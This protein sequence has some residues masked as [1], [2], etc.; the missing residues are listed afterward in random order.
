MHDFWNT[1]TPNY[2]WTW[3]TTRIVTTNHT[4]PQAPPLDEDA[5]RKIVRQELADLMPI[6]VPDHLPEA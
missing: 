6:D 2:G 3:T 5:V 4:Q 1:G